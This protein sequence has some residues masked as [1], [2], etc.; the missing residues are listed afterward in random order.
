VLF[1][2]VI[3]AAANNDDDDNNN[4]NNNNSQHSSTILFLFSYRAF[5]YSL[6]SKQQILLIKVQQNAS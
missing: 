1:S 5:S 3:A 6:Y 4:N 2:F